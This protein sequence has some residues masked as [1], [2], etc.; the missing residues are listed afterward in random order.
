MARA[1]SI[2]DSI[3]YFSCVCMCHFVFFLPLRTSSTM[4]CMSSN[5]N[6]EHEHEHCAVTVTA[7][8][9]LYGGGLSSVYRNDCNERKISTIFLYIYIF[10]ALVSCIV[11]RRGAHVCPFYGRI[12][13]W[14]ANNNIHLIYIPLANKLKFSHLTNLL[15]SIILLL[16]FVVCSALLSATH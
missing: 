12:Q 5:W 2:F 7:V 14:Q 6:T 8:V 11:C 16:N 1:S 10:L 9:R 13:M 15:R 4:H 3:L